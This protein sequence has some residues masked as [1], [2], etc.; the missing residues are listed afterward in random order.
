M[1]AM[2]GGFD[3]NTEAVLNEEDQTWWGKHSSGLNW[4]TYQPRELYISK[5]QPVKL[6]F[7][8]W[9][10]VTSIKLKIKLA[11]T[12]DTYSTITQET[13][14]ANQYEV[15]DAILSYQKLNLAAQAKDVASYEV[16][17]EDQDVNRLT[18]SRW[19]Y[20]DDTYRED[21]RISIFQNSL[22][23]PDVVRFTGS[24][25]YKTENTRST[26]E[27]INQEGFTWANFE[28]FDYS[29]TEIQQFKFRSGYLNDLAKRP[30]QYADYLR[31][32]YLSPKIYELINNRL[33]PTRLT[34][35]KNFISNSDDSLINIE[36]EA[37]RAYSDKR[38]SRDENI[39]TGQGWDSK[40]TGNYLKPE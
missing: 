33:Y 23:R 5:T 9:K 21:E 2:L 8:I 19:F 15:Y 22:G 6:S 29:N 40:F 12:D 13:Q 4:L 1:R 39:H 32:F 27:L 11:F 18:L 38:Y 14:A 3:R 7:L 36:F 31:E 24:W 28:N 37:E 35:K 26:A 25:D 16:W 17:L 30:K 20:V 10:S 34:S